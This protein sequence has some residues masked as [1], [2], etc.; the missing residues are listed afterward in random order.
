MADNTFPTPL[1]KK[2]LAFVKNLLE[3]KLP[4]HVVYHNWAHTWE[5]TEAAI[6]IGLAEGISVD[7]MERLALAALFHDTGHTRNYQL[8]EDCSKDVA[9][10]Y[11][12]S[13]GCD[14]NYIQSVLDIIGSTKMPQ[15]PKNNL[16]MIMCDADLFYLTSE[17]F[18]EKAQLLREEWGM[19]FN[20]SYTDQEW[21]KQNIGFL[22][23]HQYF[24]NYGRTVLEERKAH[25]IA[26]Q[27]QLLSSIIQS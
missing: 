10:E 19:Q 17:L 26:V 3:S 8:H 5:V 15:R 4:A 25:I 7:E 16:E 27:K 18:D 12:Q 6:E 23:S 24:T 11:L 14:S 13:Q 22:E 1:F 2:T 20:R 21:L 9:T